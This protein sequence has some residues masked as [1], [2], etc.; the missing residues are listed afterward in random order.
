MNIICPEA[1]DGGLLLGRW[2]GGPGAGDGDEG[3]DR[4]ETLEG[5]VGDREDVVVVAEIDVDGGAELL[6]V[7]DR[8]RFL[9]GGFGSGEDGEE[10][11]GQDGDDR[12]HDEQFDQG[13]GS[14]G[15]G[16]EGS[17][18]FGRLYYGNEETLGRLKGTGSAPALRL[19]GPNPK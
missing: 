5:S 11:C 16:F 6:E 10:D 19:Q 3:I 7:A 8:G 18:V 12:N 17:N 1:I 13:E 4:I 14:F 9:G 15:Q 2:G